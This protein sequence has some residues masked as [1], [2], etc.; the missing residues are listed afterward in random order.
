MPLYEGATQRIAL[1]LDAI[2]RGRWGDIIAVGRIKMQQFGRIAEAR[3]SRG[4]PGP[5]SDEIVYLGRHHLE[6]RAAQGYLVRDLVAQLASALAADA[7]VV[8]AGKMIGLM[9]RCERDD[10]YGC[11]VRDKAILEFTA[12]KPRIEVFSVIP[13]GD[14]RIPKTTKPRRGGFE[15]RSIG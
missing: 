5:E 2:A 11:R 9:N 10:G 14:G 15:E 12:R 8:A 3:L 6:S 1:Q 4:L 7:D 13:V